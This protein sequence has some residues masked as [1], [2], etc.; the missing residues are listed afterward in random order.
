MNMFE[1]EMYSL[2]VMWRPSFVGIA[3]YD[4]YTICSMQT[5]RKPWH[6]VKLI[7]FSPGCTLTIKEQHK[8]P[9]R[10][11]A[12]HN[13]KLFKSLNPDMFQCSFTS[14]EQETHIS[15]FLL[16]FHSD[17]QFKARCGN[18]GGSCIVSEKPL[19]LAHPCKEFSHHFATGLL[20]RVGLG[21]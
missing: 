12:I 1:Y 2:F 17:L 13:R 10:W 5:K 3:S 14:I 18:G 20:R 19:H 11:V 21:S 7:L 9:H 15:F 4:S 8:A 6:M 16:D